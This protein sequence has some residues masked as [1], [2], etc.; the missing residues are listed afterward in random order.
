MLTVQ[1]LA[2]ELGIH[3]ETVLRNIRKGK[4][5]AIKYGKLLRISEEELARIQR[6][7]F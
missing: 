3:K 5:K 6:E 4:I 7:G 1:E 2:K